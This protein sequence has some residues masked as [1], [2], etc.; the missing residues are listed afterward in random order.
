MFAS[1]LSACG[2]ELIRKRERNPH[3]VWELLSDRPLLRIGLRGER[4]RCPFR[5]GRRR[6]W[7]SVPRWRASHPRQDFRM[8][9]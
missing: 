4:I 5:S 1:S 8:L 2:W 6:K 9:P 3:E 7:T